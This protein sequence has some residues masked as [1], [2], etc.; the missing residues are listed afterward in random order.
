MVGRR[1]NLTAEML[2]YADDD[3]AETFYVSPSSKI[4]FTGKCDVFCDT[5]HGI[6]GDPYTLEGSF[7]AFLPRHKDA[8]R[9]VI[10]FELTNFDVQISLKP[11]CFRYG[12]IH[13]DDLMQRED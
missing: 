13:G 6:C 9:K 4:C 8:R 7:A 12:D 2:P 3:L 5:N 10:S 11:S 1:I